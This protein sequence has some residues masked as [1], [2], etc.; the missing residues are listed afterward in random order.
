[1]VRLVISCLLK[2]GK[3]PFKKRDWRYKVEDLCDKHP[4]QFRWSLGFSEIKVLY[5]K[6]DQESLC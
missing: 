4:Q 5:E 1:M 3:G 2:N 6:S